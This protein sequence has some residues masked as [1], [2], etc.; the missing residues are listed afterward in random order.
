MAELQVAGIGE[1]IRDLNALAED[2]PALC[3]QILQAQA[4]VVEPALKRSISANGLR[5][6]G[7]LLASIARRKGRSK[8]GPAVRIGPRGEH[9][10]Y[11]PRT[12][13]GVVSA[14]YV[15]YIHEYGLPSRGIKASKWAASAVSDSQEKTMAAAEQVHDRM[16]QKHNL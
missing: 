12:G 4:E 14:G 16:L 6:T 8:G 5:R 3:D 11:Y 7:R 1:L 2:T 9:H 10:R 13:S 15:G